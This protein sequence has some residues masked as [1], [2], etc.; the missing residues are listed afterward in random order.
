MYVHVSFSNPLTYCKKIAVHNEILILC[1]KCNRD[2]AFDQISDLDTTRTTWKVKA[3]VSRMWPSISNQAAEGR[4]SLKGY[5]LILL[6]D[7]VSDP[8]LYAV[9]VYF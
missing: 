8:I 7:D 6:D 2:M 5:N 9:T 4:D 3:R 1:V